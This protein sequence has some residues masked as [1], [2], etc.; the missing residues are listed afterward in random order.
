MIRF[1]VI[2]YKVNNPELLTVPDWE[3][4]PDSYPYTGRGFTGSKEVILPEFYQNERAFSEGDSLKVV[5]AK[6]GQVSTMFI[7]D[8]KMGWLLVE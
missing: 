5:D 8:K 3:A 4:T 6:G 7:Y 1:G 2:N